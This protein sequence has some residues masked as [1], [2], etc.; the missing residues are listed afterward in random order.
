MGG[1][2]WEVGGG[3]WEVGGGRWEVG[4]GRWERQRL[5]RGRAGQGE[6][7]MGNGEDVVRRLRRRGREGPL[8]RMGQRGAAWPSLDF[9]LGTLDLEAG[10]R[11]A[12]E[13]CA[14]AGECE[15]RTK[16]KREKQ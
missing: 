12:T 5:A 7:R 10:R 1:G 8:S 11:K 9:G 16:W 13:R 6:W 3:R 4:G 15:T 2:K 14:I